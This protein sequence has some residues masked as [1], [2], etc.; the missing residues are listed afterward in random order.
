MIIYTIVPFFGEAIT[1]NVEVS[2]KMSLPRCLALENA[3]RS[4]A[5]RKISKIGVVVRSNLLNNVERNDR[6]DGTRK[7]FNEKASGVH[8][9]TVL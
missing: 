8:R 2:R 3:V 1:L 6:S 9:L 4:Y 7:T 5:S